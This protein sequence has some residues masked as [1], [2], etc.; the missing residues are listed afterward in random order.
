[1]IGIIDYGLGNIR[2]VAGALDYIGQEHVISSDI[3]VLDSVDKLILPG[4]GAFADGMRRL[5][6]LSLIDF[7]NDKVLE[8]GTP[9]LGICLGFQLFAKSSDEFGLH[10][11]LGWLDANVVK[12]AVSEDSRLPH[13]G[14]N[15]SYWSESHLLFKDIPKSALFYYVHSHHVSSSDKTLICAECEYSQR[16]IASAH[17]DNIFGVQFHPEKSQ[18][19]GLQLLNN[20]CEF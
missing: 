5:K 14:W 1:M 3:C 15:D 9:I 12:L 13:I 4:V 20:F 8:Q 16:F 2:S 7:L 6:E 17:K 18:K 19:A 11:G 10:E